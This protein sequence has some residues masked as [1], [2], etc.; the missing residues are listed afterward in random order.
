MSVIHS[1]YIKKSISDNNNF[2][3]NVRIHIL[4]SH[5]LHNKPNIIISNYISDRIEHFFIFLLKKPI[6]LLLGETI[7]KDLKVYN[8]FDVTPI[9]DKN[10]YDFTKK[11]I[12]EK[13]NEGKYVFCYINTRSYITR[14]NYGKYRSGIF[15][16][17]RELN[18][19]ITLVAFDNIDMTWYGTIKEQPFIMN[20][21]PT[22]YVSPTKSINYY[23]YNTKKFF[24][25]NT[26]KFERIKTFL[27]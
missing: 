17:A 8:F 15:K 4:N 16:I 22:F 13:I 7:C 12:T 18:I 9:P 11:S 27:E 25:K 24:K 23:K 26:K 6:S 19:P 21:G 14:H 20:I 5:K 2:F 10:S 3:D 1:C